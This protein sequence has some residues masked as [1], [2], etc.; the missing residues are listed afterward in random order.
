MMVMVLIKKF[1]MSCPGLLPLR[2]ISFLEVAF[3]PYLPYLPEAHSLAEAK[4][5]EH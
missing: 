5:T 4:C 3:Y 2:R 1:M